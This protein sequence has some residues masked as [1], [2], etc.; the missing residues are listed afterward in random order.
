MVQKSKLLVNKY[1]EILLD[2]P[3]AFNALKLIREN[4]LLKEKLKF[5]EGFTITL[6]ESTYFSEDLIFIS[7]DFEKIKIKL[8][9]INV[10]HNES[11]LKYVDKIQNLIALNLIKL[12]PKIESLKEEEFNKLK[13][14]FEIY[15]LTHK[16]LNYSTIPN[17]HVPS[18]S[19]EKMALRKFSII[20]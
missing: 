4:R 8:N 17:L 3:L 10:G 14:I 7:D 20:N 11:D 13:D 19:P 5:N 12:F 16:I 9:K 18:V 2:N 6:E 15:I 1:E